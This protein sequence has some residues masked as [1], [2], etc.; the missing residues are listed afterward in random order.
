LA[1][2][3]AAVSAIAGDKKEVDARERDRAATARPF[4]RG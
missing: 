3:E 2:D 4:L 1:V